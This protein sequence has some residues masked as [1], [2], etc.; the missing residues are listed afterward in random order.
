MDRHGKEPFPFS[1]TFEQYPFKYIDNNG[2]GKTNKKLPFL[3]GLISKNNKL[4]RI[5]DSNKYP[6]QKQGITRTY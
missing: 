6:H 3:G 2:D 4:G 5:H 1:P